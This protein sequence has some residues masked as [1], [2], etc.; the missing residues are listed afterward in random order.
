MKTSKPGFHINM[1]HINIAMWNLCLG[2]TNKKDVVTGYLTSNNIH[3]CCLQETEVPL[4]FP[5]KLLNC[6]GYNIEL[7][8][9]SQKKRVGIYIQRDVVYKRRIDLEKEDHHIVIICLYVV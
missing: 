7:E 6:G 8:Q 1:H 5:E 4:G 9:N 3:V 2:I